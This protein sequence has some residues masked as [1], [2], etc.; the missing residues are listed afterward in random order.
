M[1]IQ[2][3]LKGYTVKKSNKHVEIHVW[4]PQ[5]KMINK[6]LEIYE[7]PEELSTEKRKPIWKKES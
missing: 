5:D 4:E 7:I 1:R 6:T 2:F 3:G